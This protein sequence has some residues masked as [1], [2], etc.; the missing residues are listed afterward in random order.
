MPYLFSKIESNKVKIDSIQPVV[1][2]AEVK[3]VIRRSEG[4]VSVVCDAQSM[5]NSVAMTPA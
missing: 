2:R 1:F 5:R 3:W 4:A